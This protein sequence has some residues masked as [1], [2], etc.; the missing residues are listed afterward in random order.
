MQVVVFWRRFKGVS[1]FGEPGDFP[2]PTIT[3]TGMVL[4]ERLRRM[5]RLR[6]LS[7]QDACFRVQQEVSRQARLGNNE[8]S[9]VGHSNWIRENWPSWLTTQGFHVDLTGDEYEIV[10]LNHLA[11]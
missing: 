2:P 4:L 1:F 11:A 7:Y 3:E 6:A 5:P 10:P 8:R 9:V